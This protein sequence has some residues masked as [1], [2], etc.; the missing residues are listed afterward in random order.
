MSK[1][2][3]VSF[4][5]SVLLSTNEIC[6]HFCWHFF[7]KVS[8]DFSCWRQPIEAFLEAVH[9]TKDFVKSGEMDRSKASRLLFLV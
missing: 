6:W 9:K 4:F 5:N 1:I 3:P 8:F 2:T 7:D